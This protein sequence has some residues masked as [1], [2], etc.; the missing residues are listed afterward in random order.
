ME[1]YIVK[2]EDLKEKIKDFPLEVV[3]RMVNCHIEQYGEIDLKD[4]ILASVIPEGLFEWSKTQEGQEFWNDVI[5]HEN[6]DL[7]FKKYPKSGVSNI[8]VSNVSNLKLIAISFIATLVFL[9]FVI[10][11]CLGIIS[12][13][14][15][16]NDYVV[17]A[18]MIIL[19]VVVF[20]MQYMKIYK[21]IKGILTNKNK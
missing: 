15:N 18:I 20:S 5:N 10:L 12:I 7:F 13:C 3:Q 19:S 21:D 4:I 6:F 11:L 14:K 2:P 8:K 1:K 16:S 17:A 9:S